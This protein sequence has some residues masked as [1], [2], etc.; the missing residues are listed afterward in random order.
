MKKI[1]AIVVATLMIFAITSCGD[2][3]TGTTKDK[4]TE[5]VV[6][7]TAAPTYTQPKEEPAMNQD[8]LDVKINAIVNAI[9]TKRRLAIKSEAMTAVIETQTLLQLIESG[10]KKEAIEEGHRLI[11]KFKVLLLKDP[12]VS[13]ILVDANFHKDMLITDIETVRSIANTAKLEIENRHYQDAAAL[14]NKLKSEIV[15]QNVLIP[16]AT[17][18]DAIKVAIALLKDGNTE[19]SKMILQQVLGTLIIEKTILPIPILK[20]EQFIIAASKIKVDAEN[21]IEAATNLINHADYQLHLAEEMGYGKK[22]KAYAEL[23]KSLHDLKDSVMNG[24][25]Q[26]TSDKG[27]KVLSGALHQFRERLFPSKIN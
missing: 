4:G 5:E 18:P 14:L 1:N 13:T 3:K 22:D 26:A 7:K 8:S 21:Y 6:E 12:S 24:I 16:A 15:I 9:I 25:D 10:K 17:Y 11:G 19:A 23:Y 2:K 20:A 27:F